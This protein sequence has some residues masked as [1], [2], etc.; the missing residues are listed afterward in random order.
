MKLPIR[1]ERLTLRPLTLDDLDG[2]ALLF[3]DP[4]VVRY[5]Y[6]SPMG[7]AEAAE[8]LGARMNHAL[9]GNGEWM[10]LAVEVEG[11]YIGEVGLGLV[12]AV[13]RQCEVGYLLLPQEQGRGYA[14]EATAA[15]IDLAFGELDAHR[16]V[17]RLDERNAPSE[18]VLKRLGMRREGRLVE[19]EW[20]K[21]EWT[22]EVVY[23]ITAAE[24]AAARAT[25]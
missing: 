20:V 15:M 24:W 22:T 10:N 3:G 11:R 4:D 23:A 16:V 2:H 6:E 17:G 19:N 7:R 1:T 14:T 18:R 21:G 25:R 12:S 5:V 13:H 8:H 9:P